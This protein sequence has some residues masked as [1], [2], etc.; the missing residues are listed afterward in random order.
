MYVPHA[1]QDDDLEDL[2]TFMRDHAFAM[3]VSS[4]D[5]GAPV[6]THV[7]VAVAR[8]GGTIVLRG[9]FAKA[10]P[11]WRR[12]EAGETLVVFTGPHAYVSPRHYDARESVPTWNYRAVH[13]Y[14]HARIAERDGTLDGLHALIDEHETDYRA[15]WDG[16]SERYREG[17]LGGIVGFEIVVE[18]LEGA[19]KLSQNKRLREQE[20]IAEALADGDDHDA[21]ATGCEM[22]RRLG[23]DVDRD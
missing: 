23:S 22:H 20:R 15:Q 4:V 14:G 21:R 8:E 19:A 9:H 10:N 11:H 6:A 17:M 3:V 13:A 16:L 7:P 18:R 5:G 1:F 12:L 2:T